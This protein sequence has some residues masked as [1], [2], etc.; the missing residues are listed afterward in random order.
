MYLSSAT[1][2]Q[3]SAGRNTEG[4][5]PE[6]LFHLVEKHFSNLVTI[7]SIAFSIQKYPVDILNAGFLRL[8]NLI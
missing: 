4:S 8:G 5:C 3:V 1:V 7:Y 2:C 6:F